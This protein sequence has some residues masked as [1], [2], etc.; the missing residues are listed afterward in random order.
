[1]V[2]MKSIE[3]QLKEIESIKHLLTP[4]EY[5]TKRKAILTQIGGG[6][7][8]VAVAVPVDEM[9]NASLAE[10]GDE[11][12]GLMDSLKD[13]VKD[14]TFL[15]G[16]GVG[17]LAGAVT[18]AGITHLVH[19]NKDSDSSDSDDSGKKKKSKK[20]KKK[21]KKKKSRGSSSSSSSSDSDWD[22]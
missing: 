18:G 4:D 9:A 1:M 6:G 13:T 3:E 14:K 15:K 17:F 10:T 20:K 16:A 21:K 12:K 19:K 2:E 8:T 22:Y 5:D 7:G 11:K